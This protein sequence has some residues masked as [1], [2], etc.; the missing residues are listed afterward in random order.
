MKRILLT[1]FVM[2]FFG[3]AASAQLENTRWRNTLNV[4]DPVDCE[5]VFKKDTLEAYT[6]ANSQLIEVMSYKLTKDTLRIVKISGTSPCSDVVGIYKAVL[7]DN[8]LTITPI[9]DACVER[10]GAFRP[11][12]WT[13]VQQKP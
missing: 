6:V 13:R 1:A 3:L 12:P 7:K 9:D 8:Q 2:G 5:F 4:P 11:E 10:S